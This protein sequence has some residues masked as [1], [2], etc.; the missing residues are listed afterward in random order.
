M[1][2]FRPVLPPSPEADTVGMN[3]EMWLFDGQRDYLR[4]LA[5][6]KAREH[7]QVR[8]ISRRKSQ[9]QHNLNVRHR[10]HHDRHGVHHGVCPGDLSAAI[11]MSH[12]RAWRPVAG[13]RGEMSIARVII[14][15][16]SRMCLHRETSHRSVRA[17]NH[18]QRTRH[19]TW[20]VV[21]PA[22]DG[23]DAVVAGR[24]NVVVGDAFRRNGGGIC[25]GDRGRVATS[26]AQR[27]AATS[28]HPEL[29]CR[30]L[31][32]AAESPT[33]IYAMTVAS[34]GTFDQPRGRRSP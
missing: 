17:L 8:M 24:S 15:C 27:S 16:Q 6:Y 32:A 21:M 13:C 4:Q 3:E 19:V 20:I 7:R 31:C 9:G 14:R 23:P 12:P 34:A 28:V 30:V 33:V 11:T 29:D 2:Q 10:G 26:Q 1:R 5:I 22:G 18:H 25:R